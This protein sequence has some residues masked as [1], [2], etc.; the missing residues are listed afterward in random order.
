MLKSNLLKRTF[1]FVGKISPHFQKR[2]KKGIVTLLII[3]ATVIV[4][5]PNPVMTL[6]KEVNS[7]T[8]VTASEPD[9]LAELTSLNYRMDDLNSNLEE[10]IEELK[11][12]NFELDVV[13][14]FLSYI[15]ATLIW[16]IICIALFVVYK[17]LYKFFRF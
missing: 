16:I 10:E 4:A 13:I 5:E 11:D 9:V 6:A 8:E 1:F 2:K 3:I 17:L 7:S 12:I 15:F 14:G